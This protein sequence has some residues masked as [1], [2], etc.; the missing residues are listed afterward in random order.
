[1]QG[2]KI[3]FNENTKNAADYAMTIIASSNA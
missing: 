1:M 3:K 2:Y